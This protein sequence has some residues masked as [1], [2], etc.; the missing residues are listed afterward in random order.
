MNMNTNE[1]ETILA[2]INDMQ[3]NLQ[4]KIQNSIPVTELS[5]DL[6][7]IRSELNSLRETTEDGFKRL[8]ELL[9]S[10]PIIT[11]K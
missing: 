8:I 9:E 1:L 2:T 10:S 5:T 4:R 3:S 7:E 11:E 6:G